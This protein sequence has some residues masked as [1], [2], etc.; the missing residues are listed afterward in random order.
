MSIINE[1]DTQKRTKRNFQNRIRFDDPIKMRK[2]Y[3]QAT[4]SLIQTKGQQ[5]QIGQG[6]TTDP[7]LFTILHEFT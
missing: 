3:I 6:S 1:D 5:V 2:H 7:G 4:Y